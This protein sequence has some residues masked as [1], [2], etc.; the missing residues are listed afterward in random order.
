MENKETKNS[1]EIYFEKIKNVAKFKM[2]LKETMNLLNTNLN[3][4]ANNYST[5]NDPKNSNRISIN[6]K[7][8]NFNL[9]KF[10]M[11]LITQHCKN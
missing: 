7:K 3:N 8:I 4:G 2:K 5:N 6:V 10:R 1:C 9:F 11:Q